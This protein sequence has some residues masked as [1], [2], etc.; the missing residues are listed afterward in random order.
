[1]CHKG[2]PE[3]LLKHK[4]DGELKEREKEADQRQRSE[5]Q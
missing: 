4:C 2:I 1:M 5:E 3:I